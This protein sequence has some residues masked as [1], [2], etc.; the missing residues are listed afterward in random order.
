MAFMDAGIR[1]N[2]A[3]QAYF[4]TFSRVAMTSSVFNVD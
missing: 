4:G 1:A 2:K 3:A